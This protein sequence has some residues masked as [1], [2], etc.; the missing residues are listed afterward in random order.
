MFNQYITSL[1]YTVAAIGGN[2]MGPR[3]DIEITFTILELFIMLFINDIF[4]GEIINLIA[5]MSEKSVYF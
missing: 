1:Y 3:T 5:Q 2:E 4:I